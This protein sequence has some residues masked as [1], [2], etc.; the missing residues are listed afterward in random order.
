MRKK[1]IGNIYMPPKTHFSLNYLNF[2]TNSTKEIQGETN[3][4]PIP[5]IEKNQSCFS[6]PSTT[7]FEGH[8][9]NYRKFSNSDESKEQQEDRKTIENINKIKIQDLENEPIS[10]KFVEKDILNVESETPK[11]QTSESQNASISKTDDIDSD[12][13]IEKY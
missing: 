11:P 8:P 5:S 4:L 13:T 2:R 9:V 7:L 3:L 12:E 6:V 1:R 10:P